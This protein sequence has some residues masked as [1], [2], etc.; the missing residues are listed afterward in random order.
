MNLLQQIT[1]C[2]KQITQIETNTDMQQLPAAL[3][4]NMADNLKTTKAIMSQAELMLSEQIGAQGEGTAK[5]RL[6]ER[7]LLDLS[8]HNNLLNMKVG[9]NVQPMACADI[10]QMEDELSQGR[11]LLLEQ[12]ELK[13]IYRAMRTNLEEMGAN[14]LFIALGSLRWCERLG[15]RTYTAPSYC[16]P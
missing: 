13:G 10:C 14:T 1:A 4:A 9:K 7:K 12:S 6:W 3:R 16:Y 11:E 8:L 5:L 15:G 2:K